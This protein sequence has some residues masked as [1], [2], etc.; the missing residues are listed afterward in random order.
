[1]ENVTECFT[2]R[3][4]ET[5]KPLPNDFIEPIEEIMKRQYAYVDFKKK[6]ND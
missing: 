2:I 1:M 5:M 3:M 4:G 6:E